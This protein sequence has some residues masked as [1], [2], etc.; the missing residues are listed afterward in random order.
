MTK[1]IHR[2][3]V[4]SGL[5]RREVVKVY[6]SENKALQQLTLLGGEIEYVVTTKII[7]GKDIK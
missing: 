1:Y 2:F 3:K 5:N 7:K 4:S 6:D